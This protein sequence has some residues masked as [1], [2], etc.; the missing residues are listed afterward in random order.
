MRLKLLLVECVG[1]ALQFVPAGQAADTQSCGRS[2]SVPP[3]PSAAGRIVNDDCTGALPIAVGGS[4]FGDSTLAEDDSTP[5]CFYVPTP[6]KGLW[7]SVVGTGHTLTASTCSYSTSFDTAIEVFCDCHTLEC[8]AANDD[9]YE[10][11][12]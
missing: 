5:T 12:C 9:D 6:D 7:Y 2:P 4:A 8:V 3:Q 10:C 1:L 11:E